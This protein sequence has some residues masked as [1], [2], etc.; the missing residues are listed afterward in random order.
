MRLGWPIT[1]SLLACL[2]FPII[3]C[4]PD[5]ALDSSVSPQEQL[6]SLKCTIEGPSSDPLAGTDFTLSGI[7]PGAK[8]VRFRKAGRDADLD[9]EVGLETDDIYIFT[10]PEVEGQM[11]EAIRL[12]RADDSF[13][14]MILVEPPAAWMVNSV[15]SCDPRGVG[16]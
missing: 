5:K 15:G 1:G 10:F 7:G 16:N 4:S 6:K 12:E 11:P 2:L 14:V 8:T 3:S 9:L 13:V